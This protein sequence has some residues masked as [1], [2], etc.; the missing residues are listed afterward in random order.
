[1]IWIDES[2][3][4]AEETLAEARALTESN[5]DGAP[6][7]QILLVGLPRLRVGLQA[8]P[9]LWRRIVV[10]EELTGLVFD[11]L[12]P[13]LTHHFG[14]EQAHRL[15]DDARQILF[16]RAN[17]VPGLIAPMFRAIAE[18]FGCEPTPLDPGAVEDTLAR[19]DLA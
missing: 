11:E 14:A 19:W 3:Q 2:H 18:R 8:L 4:L 15:G 17:G 6:R 9:Y 5:L 7:V 1:M 12:Q 16:E 10:R 13:F